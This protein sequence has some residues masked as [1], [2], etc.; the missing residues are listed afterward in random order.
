MRTHRDIVQAHGASA[1]VRD[2]AGMGIKVHQSTPQRWAE[3]DSVPGEYWAAL[4]SLGAANLEELA[5]AAAR[6]TA[7]PPAAQGAAA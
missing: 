4:V 5:A 7:D 3:R 2:L 6:K 1:L